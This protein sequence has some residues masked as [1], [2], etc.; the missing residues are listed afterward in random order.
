[1]PVVVVVVHLPGMQLGLVAVVPM[2]NA[3]TEV[4]PNAVKSRVAAASRMILDMD[5]APCFQLFG[6][7]DLQEYLYF[8]YWELFA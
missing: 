4:E 8:P 5:F 7:I 3:E 1:V 6:G 2:L